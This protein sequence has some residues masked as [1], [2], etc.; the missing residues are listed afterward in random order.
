MIK[1]VRLSSGVGGRHFMIKIAFCDDDLLVL[2]ELSVLVDRYRVSHNREIAYTTYNSPLELL[3][4]IERGTRYDILF[5]DVLMPGENGIETAREIRTWDKSV[6]I[7]FLTSSEEF[8]V[9]SY[10]VGGILLSAQAHLGRELRPPDG[11]C[12][13]RMHQIPERQFDIEM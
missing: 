8:A 2:N 11:F 13:S 5:L 10:V 6:K 9:Q 4:G 12:P 3:A 7:I 1:I